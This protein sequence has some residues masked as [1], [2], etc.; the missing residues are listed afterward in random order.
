MFM[1]ALG[2]FRIK[3]D[4]NNLR[5]GM[6]VV[7][8][9]LPKSLQLQHAIISSFYPQWRNWQQPWWHGKLSGFVENVAYHQNYK[10]SIKKGM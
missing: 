9:D 4:I 1:V 6:H 2:S 7:K 10:N 3:L 5:S 8:K